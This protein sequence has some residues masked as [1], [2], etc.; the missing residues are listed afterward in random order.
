MISSRVSRILC[1][2]LLSFLGAFALR[3]FALCLLH[4]YPLE[5]GE[6]VNRLWSA[7]IAGGQALYPAILPETLPHLH[8]PY[9]PLGPWLVHNLARILPPL[10]PFFAGRILALAGT[11]LAAQAI[12]ALVRKRSAGPDAA[13][14]ASLLFLLS[15][16]VLRFGVMLRYDPVAL[17]LSL[18]ALRLLD[19]SKS[20]ARTGLAS[21]CAMSALLIKPT[22]I[23][24]ALLLIILCLRPFQRKAFSAAAL[25][26]ILPFTLLLFWLY[27]RESPRLLLHLW[28]LQGLPADPSGLLAWLGPFAGFHAPVLAFAAATFLHSPPSDRN[29]RLYAALACI[30]PPLTAL[31]TGSQENYL[32][33]L[34]AL[35]CIGAGIGAARLQP[36]PP[37]YPVAAL[38]QLLLFLPFPSAP[39]F[40]RTYGQ[41]LPAT[42][43]PSAT[44]AAADTDIG[45]LL[46]MELRTAVG[47]ILS[48]DLGYLAALDAAP[49]FQPFQFGHLARAGKWDLTVLDQALRGEQFAY[50]LLK[51]LAENGEDP[52]FPD[53]QQALIHQHYE[54]HRVLGPW[55]LYR[56]VH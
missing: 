17:G 20:P 3:H 12:F 23:A 43:R 6:G 44:P 36:K 2:L 4:P 14:L 50:V 18:Q 19:R 21:A 54:L 32:L 47:P 9:P 48:S 31:V 22:F 40:T 49:L 45:H 29:I 42:S 37:V 46:H 33:E 28:T 41:E 11:L 26:A 16:M 35:A 56:R 55:H 38:L 27:Q 13:M 30:A 34:W 24:P 51:G 7:R 8:N 53:A 15:P 39:V 5:Y 25:G 52:Y 1:L 10:H